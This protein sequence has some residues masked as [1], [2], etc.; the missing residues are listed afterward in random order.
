MVVDMKISLAVETKGPAGMLCQ[1]VKHLKS[2]NPGAE[3]HGQEIRCL[4]L[5]LWSERR[6]IEL[7][8]RNLGRR[9]WGEGLAWVCLAKSH[10]PDSEIPSQQEHLDSY[11]HFCLVCVSVQYCRPHVHDPP[12][13]SLKPFSVNLFKR[14]LV[15]GFLGFLNCNGFRAFT[16]RF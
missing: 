16:E 14:G 4:Y 15:I 11:L 3:I 5:D 6:W 2:E 12:S 8:G 1:C 9:R 13:D 10:R 7:H